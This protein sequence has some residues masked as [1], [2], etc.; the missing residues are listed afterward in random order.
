MTRAVVTIF[1]LLA[2]WSGFRDQASAAV[3]SYQVTRSGTLGG[4][5]SQGQDINAGGQVT[6]E[7]YGTGDTPY[8]TFRWTPLY[9]MATSARW[10]TWG[11]LG[12]SFSVGYGIN[13]IGHVRAASRI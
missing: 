3:I 10:S 7:S 8:H 4:T 6:G 13:A 9:P 2:A 5:F 11:T 12:G 1:L